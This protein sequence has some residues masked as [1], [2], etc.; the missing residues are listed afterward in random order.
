[1]PPIDNAIILEPIK[2]FPLDFS[3]GFK[4]NLGL[5]IK[6]NLDK[7]KNELSFLV[8]KKVSPFQ[9]NSLIGYIEGKTPPFHYTTTFRHAKVYEE[10]YNLVSLQDLRV[11]IENELLTTPAIRMKI[12]W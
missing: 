11:Y 1:M 2:K 3:E 6:T 5:Y 10:V 9:L 4:K 7:K 12:T 8:R